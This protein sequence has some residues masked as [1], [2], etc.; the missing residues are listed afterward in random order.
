M[1]S[2]IS[3]FKFERRVTDPPIQHRRILKEDQDYSIPIDHSVEELLPLE[4]HEMFGVGAAYDK[5]VVVNLKTGKV[6][7]TPTKASLVSQFPDSA[8]PN[9]IQYGGEAAYLGT[10]NGISS[11]DTNSP[12]IAPCLLNGAEMD[13]TLI[14][15][16]AQDKA[17]GWTTNNSHDFSMAFV[18]GKAEGANEHWIHPYTVNRNSQ[19]VQLDM[20]L[21][22]IITGLDISNLNVAQMTTLSYLFRS[23]PTKGSDVIGGWSNALKDLPVSM[24]YIDKALFNLY[25]RNRT[26]RF[27]R[28]V[29]DSGTI[30]FLLGCMEA[31]RAMRRGKFTRNIK[32]SANVSAAAL[33]NTNVALPIGLEGTFIA[34]GTINPF[35]HV[36]ETETESFLI[37]PAFL[38]PFLDQTNMINDVRDEEMMDIERSDM[39]QMLSLIFENADPEEG[40]NLVTRQRTRMLLFD[41][42]D[43]GSF[44]DFTDFKSTTGA[45]AAA[46]LGYESPRDLFNRTGANTNGPVGTGTPGRIGYYNSIMNHTGTLIGQNRLDFLNDLDEIKDETFM[47]ASTEKLHSGSTLAAPFGTQSMLTRTRFGD[48]HV[49][50]KVYPGG[51]LYPTVMIQ[52]RWTAEQTKITSTGPTQWDNDALGVANYADYYDLCT[53]QVLHVIPTY[54]WNILNGNCDTRGLVPASNS[55]QA[56]YDVFTNT[57]TEYGVDT[58]L[59]QASGYN[60]VTTQLFD[61]AGHSPLWLEANHKMNS[62]NINIVRLRLRTQLYREWVD[63]GDTIRNDDSG[64][65]TVFSSLNVLQESYFTTPPAVLQRNFKDVRHLLTQASNDVDGFTTPTE[66]RHGHPL[67]C[68]WKNGMYLTGDNPSNIDFSQDRELFT[69]GSTLQ[70]RNTG[71][72][73]SSILHTQ[74]PPEDTLGFYALCAYLNLHSDLGL[75]NRPLINK[76]VASSDVAWNQELVIYQSKKTYDGV[77]SDVSC[78]PICGQVHSSTDGGTAATSMFPHAGNLSASK[79]Q[80]WDWKPSSWRHNVTGTSSS[81]VPAT[82]VYTPFDVSTGH[83]E[84]RFIGNSYYFI[85]GDYTTVLA[86][87][88]ASKTMYDTLVKGHNWLM[89]PFARPTSEVLDV[90]SPAKQKTFVELFS[91]KDWFTVYGGNTITTGTPDDT[92]QSDLWTFMDFY[93]RAIENIRD[94]LEW[95]HH[96]PHLILFDNDINDKQEFMLNS[97]LLMSNRSTRGPLTFY[98]VLDATGKSV[99]SGSLTGEASIEFIDNASGVGSSESDLV[100][101]PDDDGAG[102]TAPS[103]G[104]TTVP[105]A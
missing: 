71:Y 40:M 63:R 67:S 94:D 77:V 2:E 69:A 92:Y 31:G 60:A 84:W 96:A 53:V 95:Q 75:S 68:G 79:F 74:K 65:L 22:D 44:V 1:A 66:W 11:S 61:P 18:T 81:P 87:S 37:C 89:R 38:Y 42:F 14:F 8:G 49:E 4:T 97:I 35:F 86:A 39:F 58:A 73:I 57:V 12:T 59:V 9:W 101:D 52:Y 32:V 85:L 29:G 55:R 16:A 41:R 105:N 21:N 93:G 5:L 98:T 25:Y 78:T 23:I 54:G 100:T 50:G 7:F 36:Y 88:I 104:I 103:M 6:G 45:L 43:E 47:L 91:S 24:Q 19:S 80:T 46:L 62:D 90:Q 70:A 34:G 48:H 64:S 10:V 51:L 30:P 83:M 27:P 15:N 99:S 56:L 20:P 33:H 82:H 3:N 13:P 17:H 72:S 76:F 26:T 102:E 28:A